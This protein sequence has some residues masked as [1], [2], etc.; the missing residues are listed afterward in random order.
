MLH[1]HVTLDA[2]QGFIRCDWRD[3][4]RRLQVS[5]GII[6]CTGSDELTWDLTVGAELETAISGHDL[7]S[8]RDQLNRWLH[9]FPTSREAFTAS[10]VQTKRDSPKP[11]LCPG[12]AFWPRRIARFLA[13]GEH[14]RDG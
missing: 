9:R 4:E 8:I 10:R 12:T 2:P 3:P 1:L 11:I 14:P 7:K 13:G 6:R 5:T